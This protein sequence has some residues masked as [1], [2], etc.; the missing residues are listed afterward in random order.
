MQVCTMAII[1]IFTAYLFDV[2]NIILQL[3]FRG[4]SILSN[5]NRVAFFFME[6]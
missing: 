4:I 3:E 6:I 2:V 1:E 5:L